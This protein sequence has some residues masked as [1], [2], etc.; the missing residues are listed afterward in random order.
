MTARE[1]LPDWNEGT[2]GP[3]RAPAVESE[4][5]IQSKDFA[6]LQRRRKVDQK[7]IGEI[8]FVVVILSQD[9]MKGSRATA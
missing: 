3:V 1:C 5:S 4:I 7:R 9:A 8:H 6:R 2:E